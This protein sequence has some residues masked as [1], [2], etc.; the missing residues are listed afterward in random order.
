[1]LLAS[2][3]DAMPGCL[4]EQGG[5]G[6]RYYAKMDGFPLRSLLVLNHV[7]QGL[8]MDMCCEDGN[9]E[10]WQEQAERVVE[11][12]GSRPLYAIVPETYRW[13]PG[14][15]TEVVARRYKYAYDLDQIVEPIR[16]I[17]E[18]D[19]ISVEGRE[20]QLALM[21]YESDSM[22]PTIEVAR[23]N[24]GDIYSGTYGQLLASSGLAMIGGQPVGGILLNDDFGRILIS[25]IFVNPSIQQQGW[26]KW[27]LG[28][29]LHH[30]RENEGLRTVYGSVDASNTGS[31]RFVRSFGLRQFPNIYHVVRVSL[32][33]DL[34]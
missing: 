21:L 12:A 31:N 4:V 17:P 23:Q 29:A 34:T 6:S 15:H 13:K 9:V 1:M 28:K 2:I 7:K 33:R 27:M 32:E 3:T 24:I 8:I 18:P 14:I 11:I 16:R 20:E 19:W 25:H 10:Q 30:V 26:A 5:Y 22:C